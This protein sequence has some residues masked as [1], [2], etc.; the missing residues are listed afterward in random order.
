[1][2]KTE[3]KSSS[4]EKYFQNIF[5]GIEAI[6]RGMKLTFFYLFQ[7]KVTEIY[8]DIKRKLP[9]RFRGRFAFLYNKDDGKMLCI[10]C[11]ACVKV[12]PPQTIRLETEKGA[13]KKI[14][15]NVYEIN[16]GECISCANCV[17][18]CPVGALEMTHEFET[19]TFDQNDLLFDMHKLAK[20]VERPNM[21]LPPDKAPAKK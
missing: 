21:Y 12:C 3:K 8:P 10:G 13:D 11:N 4:V 18:V 1:M 9:Q 7:A 20:Y 15:V 2:E 16:I 17:E 5:Y 6:Y 19:A 14:K